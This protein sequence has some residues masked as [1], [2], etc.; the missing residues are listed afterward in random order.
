MGAVFRKWHVLAMTK[1]CGSS[2]SRW[3]R[4]ATTEKTA[5]RIPLGFPGRARLYRE[6]EYSELSAW[7]IC[8]P[9]SAMVRK[10]GRRHR[11]HLP[12]N[13]A[14]RILKER[15]PRYK[16][17]CLTSPMSTSDRATTPP[18]TTHAQTLFDGP[19]PPCTAMLSLAV[20]RSGQLNDR[21]DMVNTPRLPDILTFQP[22][23]V[24][25]GRRKAMSSQSVHR[26]GIGDY[27][28][29]LR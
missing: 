2:T 25:L 18:W 22:T 12:L 26:V 13:G 3:S 27:H 17:N 1:T 11:Y 5:A 10:A 9:R 29:D 14:P 8:N 20:K 23:S 4:D 15:A 16:V 7:L 6:V 24:R 19:R 21:T 28:R